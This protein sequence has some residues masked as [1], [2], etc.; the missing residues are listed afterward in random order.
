MKYNFI[1]YPA[2]FA[3]SCQVHPSE[4]AYHTG[5]VT[6]SETVSCRRYADNLKAGVSTEEYIHCNG[7]QLI[8]T[9]SDLGPEQYMYSSTSKLYVWPAYTRDSRLLFIFATRVTLTTIT[10]HYYSDSDRGLPRLRFFA[11]PDDF[12]IWDA[13][14]ATD[15]FVEVAAMQ[16]DGGLAGRM[17]VSVTLN[18][19]TARVLMINLGRNIVFA[20]SEVEF[21]T[22]T[23]K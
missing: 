12:N 20:V 16:S 10:L 7:T 4:Y 17:T 9:N 23:G 18:S 2:V 6:R 5:S 13:P 21:F 11:I 15:T 19:N 22:C 3:S 1:I 8:L 14:I